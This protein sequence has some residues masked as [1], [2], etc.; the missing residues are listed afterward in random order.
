MKYYVYMLSLICMLFFSQ[1]SY[2]NEE[3]RTLNLGALSCQEW[4]DVPDHSL[5]GVF[6]EEWISG[7]INGID[8]LCF[9]EKSGK[10]ISNYI[11]SSYKGRIDQVFTSAK[12]WCKSHPDATVSS[13]TTYA[14]EHLFDDLPNISSED[15]YL[16][17][18]GKATC[19]TIVSKIKTDIGVSAVLF[20]SDGEFNGLEEKCQKDNKSFCVGGD[21]LAKADDNYMSLLFGKAV[22]HCTKNHDDHF[23][24][25]I[26]DVWSDLRHKA[27]IHHKEEE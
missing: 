2:A 20:F 16:T 25:V 18:F 12:K 7:K 26:F 15:I 27:H 9:L 3:K 21:T 19:S 13:A 6:I 24:A 1:Y 22:V 4:V 11:D 5:K 23:G 17:G 14:W 10:C 8:L